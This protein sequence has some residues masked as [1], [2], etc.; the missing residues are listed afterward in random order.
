MLSSQR[1]VAVHNISYFLFQ[2][3]GHPDAI[4][5]P[6]SGGG[7][8]SGI[9]IAVKSI[10]PKIKVIA[11]EPTGTNDAADVSKSLA[12]GELITCPFP[13]TVADGLMGEKLGAT[14]FSRVEQ[15]L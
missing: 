11:A 2:V 3:P 10:N 8:L 5:V 7:L 12:A 4:V 14:L 1:I 6:V 9:L 15:S 13:K